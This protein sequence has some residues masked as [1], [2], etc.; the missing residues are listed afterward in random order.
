MLRG[1]FM[2]IQGCFKVSSMMLKGYLVDNS[3]IILGYLK[4]TSV[5]VESLLVL[6]NVNDNS[7]F[8]KPQKIIFSR[9]LKLLIADQQQNTSRIVH[10]AVTGLA[11]IQFL[12]L[13]T[14]PTLW[15]KLLMLG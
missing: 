14:W 8:K 9:S 13:G 12:I 3:W 7:L 15:H 2:A 4:D 1:C 5:I 10:F 6:F 11:A